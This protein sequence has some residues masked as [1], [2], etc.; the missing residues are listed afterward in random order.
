MSS[1]VN[2][3]SD[4]SKFECISKPLNKNTFRF[5]DKVNRLLVKLKSI[6]VISDKIY[7]D[8]YVSGCGGPG[9]LYG[10][11]QI[12]KA[13]FHVDF[14][15]H[16]VFAPYSSPFYNLAKYFV[17]LLTPFALSKYYVTNSSSFSKE[18]CEL[19]F[20][21]GDSFMILLNIEN[22]HINVPLLESINIC[23]SRMFAVDS[24]S[25]AGFT[26][27]L[28]RET[29]ELSLRSSYFAFQ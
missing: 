28:F 13:N 22:L 2:L 15:L 16:P 17:P 4:V 5:E 14:P 7:L 23:V 12:H 3:I 20:A 27:N 10:I 24:E 19:N 18:I 25:F 29:L 26:V 9:I 8:S 6:G 1:M 11:P 21:S